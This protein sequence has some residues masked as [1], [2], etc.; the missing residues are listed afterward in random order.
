M[1]YGDLAQAVMEQTKLEAEGEVVFDSA[2]KRTPAQR[3]AERR[4]IQANAQWWYLHDERDASHFG[5]CEWCCVVLAT[6][7]GYAVDRD[8]L[9]GALMARWRERGCLLPAKHRLAAGALTWDAEDEEAPPPTAVE[10][11]AA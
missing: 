5:S 11:P 7:I 8:A 10:K 4:R 6:E 1:G 2:E 3:A 9:A